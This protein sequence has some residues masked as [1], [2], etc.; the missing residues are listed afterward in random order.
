MSKK[1]GEGM[2]EI[3]DKEGVHSECHTKRNM[4]RES[5]VVTDVYHPS[6]K[7]TEAGLPIQGLQS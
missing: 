1:N 5:A 7:E 3:H 4:S 2:G 6:T